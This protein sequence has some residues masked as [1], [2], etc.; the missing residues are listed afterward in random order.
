MSGH[1]H[2]YLSRIDQAIAAL[3]AERS[4][5]IDTPPTVA[6]QGAPGAFSE[7]AARLFFSGAVALTPVRTLD[8]VFA[9]MARGDVEF[10]V[11]PIENTLAGAVPGCLRRIRE[12]RAQV[13]GERI[14]RV[15]QAAIGVPG[16]ALSDARIARSHPVALAQCRTFFEAHPWIAPEHAFDT[17]GAVAEIIHAGD[18]AVI[19][20]GSARAAAEYGGTLLAAEI[21]DVASNFT[22]FVLLGH[23]PTRRP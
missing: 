11:V 2:P 6:Y 19:A 8:D 10:A 21:Q 5:L 15:A 3:I 18:P 20:I 4:R 9:A 22:R 16:A 13:V 23:E 7:E 14:L 12:S 1:R 17:A